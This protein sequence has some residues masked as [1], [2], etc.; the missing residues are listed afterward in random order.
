MLLALQGRYLQLGLDPGLHFIIFGRAPQSL[1]GPGL[2][3][4]PAVLLLPET[5]LDLPDP[6]QVLLLMVFRVLPWEKDVARLYPIYS[7]GDPTP[8]SSQI[9]PHTPSYRKISLTSP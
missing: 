6:L 5:P 9:S 7:P 4:L 2:A 3:L 8:T 1:Q